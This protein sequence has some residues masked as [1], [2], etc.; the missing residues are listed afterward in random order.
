MKNKQSINNVH[1]NFWTGFGLGSVMA[2]IALYAF[3]TKKGRNNLQKIMNIAENWED[4]LVSITK[5]VETVL[6]NRKEKN[7]DEN[8]NFIGQL[9]NKIKSKSN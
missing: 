7:K 6:N 1:G 5:E 2:L 8:S 4:H 3:G 9:L